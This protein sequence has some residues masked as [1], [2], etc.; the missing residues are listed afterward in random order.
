MTRFW[1]KLRLQVHSAS[2]LS[3]LPFLSLANATRVS[4]TISSY[5][6][7]YAP[8]P[9]DVMFPSKR[10]F[11]RA[12]Q[13]AASR[14][15]SPSKVQTSFTFARVTTYIYMYRARCIVQF[16]RAFEVLRRY[17]S[18]IRLYRT[19]RENVSTKRC[20]SQCVLFTMICVFFMIIIS[21]I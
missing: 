2:V 12:Q 1:P 5:K 21:R 9:R 17:I 7:P 4:P 18:C 11:R 15:F 8:F 10:S 6:L 20:F 13:P 19:H 3:F 16:V 14:L